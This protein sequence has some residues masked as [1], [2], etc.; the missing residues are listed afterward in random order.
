MH[1]AKLILAASALLLS[2]PSVGQGWIEYV[3]IADRFTMY[4]PGEPDVRDISYASEYGVVFPARMYSYEDGPSRYSV[5]VVDYTDSEG[6]HSERSNKTSADDGSL[7][8]AVD[9]LGSIAYAAWNI[10]K[11]GGKVT[12]D[13][14]HYI[15]RVEG[16]QLQ[17]T[18]ADRSRTYAGIYLHETR[19]YILEATVPPGSPPPIIFQQSL[20]LLDDEGNTFNYEYIHSPRLRIGGG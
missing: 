2:S 8:W 5:T 9:V 11:R 20:S 1:L 13:A 7:Y 6:I 14:W 12:H 18:N 17:V 16:H 15:Q 4:V 3:S 10:R 19:L